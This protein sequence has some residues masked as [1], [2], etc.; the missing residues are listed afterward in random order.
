MAVIASAVICEQVQELANGNVNCNN[1]INT[2]YGTGE[3]YFEIAVTYKTNKQDF[4]EE[5]KICYGNGEVIDSFEN[6]IKP[7]Q[8]FHVSISEIDVNLDREGVYYVEVFLDGY[9]KNKIPF[10]VVG[11]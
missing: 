5:Y 6:A 11:E 7:E 10:E 4:V 9:S 8:D 3:T 1:L 2:I